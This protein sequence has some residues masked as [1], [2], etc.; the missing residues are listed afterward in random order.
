[1]KRHPKHGRPRDVLLFIDFVIDPKRPVM[2]NLNGGTAEAYQMLPVAIAG[3]WAS[4]AKLD[5]AR[6]EVDALVKIKEGMEALAELRMT[7]VTS[8]EGER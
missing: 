8:D 5:Y 6:A 1:V 3:L 2:M 4:Q 7:R